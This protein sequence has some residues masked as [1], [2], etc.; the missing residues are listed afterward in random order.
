[1][2]QI[3]RRVLRHIGGAAAWA[4][5]LPHAS[6]AAQDGFPSGPLRFVVPLNPGS[7]GDGST[8][9]IAERMGKLLGQPAIVENRPGGDFIIGVQ[10]LLSAPP[11]GHT[12]MLLSATSMVINPIIHKDLPYDP[13]R[14]ISP[15]ATTANG[16]AA[17]VT[18]TGSRFRTVADV[19]NA[20]RKDPRSVSMGYYAQLYRV[21][22][23]MMEDMGKVRF[24]HVP[25]KGFTQESTDLIGGA[26]DVAFVD[27]GAALPS[28]RSGRLRALGVAS[29][30]R[31]PDLPEVPTLD[32]RGFPDLDLLIWVGYG[33]SAKVPQARA[34]VLQRAL[35][36]VVSQPDFRAYTSQNGS[37]EVLALPGKEVERRIAAETIRYRR[38]LE[39][40]AHAA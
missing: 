13:L 4:A 25:Y 19:M 22:G 10:A 7:G 30:R 23:L 37:L 35:L 32:E 33:V 27:A 5:M 9:F 40:A 3:R 39:N 24:S 12:L 31:H 11:D 17:L 34:E 14:D 20:A 26:L 28:I 8:R 36:Q 21:G 15:L 6:H 38:L 29:K 2:N 1:M 18:G 16:T